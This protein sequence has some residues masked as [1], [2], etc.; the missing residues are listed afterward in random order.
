MNKDLLVRHRTTRPRVPSLPHEL[1]VK[2]NDKKFFI[3][4][5]EQMMKNFWLSN[6]QYSSDSSQPISQGLD[7]LDN[8]EFHQN[9]L[10]GG[11]NKWVAI[12]YEEGGYN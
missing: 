10:M 6:W 7:F 1:W 12:D 3:R 4:L 11:C 2:Q 5:G 8:S 9:N